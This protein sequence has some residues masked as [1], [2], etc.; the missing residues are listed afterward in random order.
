MKRAV[1]FARIRTVSYPSS[2]ADLSAVSWL[3]ADGWPGVIKRVLI[4]AA[5]FSV[6]LSR[7]S[8]ARIQPASTE[9]VI[10]HSRL[11]RA[12]S[13]RAKKSGKKIKI[14]YLFF[15][16]ERDWY[17]YK[18][19]CNWKIR[20]KL[21]CFYCSRE[22]NVCVNPNNSVLFE[23]INSADYSCRWRII[24]FSIYSCNCSRPKIESVKRVA[25]LSSRSQWCSSDQI[26]RYQ[27]ISS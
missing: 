11:G 26:I 22:K 27:W 4:V 7:A 17:S 25:K 15:F 2:A 5:C 16:R 19:L 18:I 20:G 9:A 24:C 10:R 6:L 13:I 21:I 12:S 14:S 23:E 3:T 1:R 8:R